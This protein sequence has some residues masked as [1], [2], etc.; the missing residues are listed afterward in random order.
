MIPFPSLRFVSEVG[1]VKPDRETSF[2]DYFTTALDGQRNGPGHDNPRPTERVD[3]ICFHQ[4]YV[5][6]GFGYS[7]RLAKKIGPRA[8]L[9]RRFEKVPYHI[10]V[11]R[12]G[13]ILWN[14]DV[15]EY[16]FHGGRCN[17]FSIG[18][19]VDGRYPG[20]PFDDFMVETT[21]KAIALAK[22][23]S[24]QQGANLQFV[25][26]H[27]VW[28]KRRLADPGGE[29]WER[30]VMPMVERFDL[31]LSARGPRDGGETIEDLRARW[32]RNL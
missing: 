24:A 22:W 30:G 20:D 26:A 1:K 21:H 29:I 25:T 11:L 16:T 5:K 19:A 31:Q 7:K 3:T 32:R 18:L 2:R 9:H 23:K 12:N 6:G 4:T 8:A 15:W 10:V 13:D 14:N 17:R 28:S 27:G